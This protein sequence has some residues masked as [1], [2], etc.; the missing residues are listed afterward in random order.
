MNIN[1][2]ILSAGKGTRLRPLTDKLPKPLLRLDAHVTILE[3]LIDQFRSYLPIE[4]IWVNISTHAQAFIKFLGELN[5]DRRPK[6]LFEPQVLG[7]GRTL[8]ELSKLINNPTLVIHGDL[9]L[10][11]E[12]VSE[13][14]N[15]VSESDRFLMVCHSRPASRARSN[16]IVNEHNRVIDITRV[17]ETGDP[18]EELL[19]NSGIYFFPNL[20]IFSELDG[21]N[22]QVDLVDSIVPILIK[23]HELYASRIYKE[24]VSVDSIGQLEE[25]KDLIKQEKRVL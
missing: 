12:Y 10:S 5:T 16:V 19:V 22:T 20:R 1:L 7:A 9:V 6:V 25:A 3:R 15:K 21:P 23:R 2:L 17:D 4:N 13:L 8:F 18:L 14:I 24:R 11:F